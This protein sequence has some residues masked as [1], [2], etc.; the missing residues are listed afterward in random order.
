MIDDGF[1]VQLRHPRR[2]DH[3]ARCA[4]ILRLLSE[5]D[6]GP[7]PIGRGADDHLRAAG[8]LT[9][10]RVDDG[11]A[12]AFAQTRDL[13]RDAKRRHAADAGLHD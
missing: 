1:S 12:L 2:T 7:E 6:A 10:D 9:H 5:S 11:R 13:A 4:E 8:D 3:H